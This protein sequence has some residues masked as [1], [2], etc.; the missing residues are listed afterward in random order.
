MQLIVKKIEKKEVEKMEKSFSKEF[1][2][3]INQPYYS[4]KVFKFYTYK[5][6]F[7]IEDEN[8][9]LKIDAEHYYDWQYVSTSYTWDYIFLAIADKKIGID[10]ETIKE[11][12]PEMIDF[13]SKEEYDFLWEKTR[14]N[15]FF[16][17]TAEECIIKTS[18]ACFFEDGKNVKIKSLE[19]KEQEIWGLSFSYE[20]IMTL[21]E[22]DYKV[23]TWKIDNLIY[24]ISMLVKN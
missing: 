8:L 18:N 12:S 5:R 22:K 20:S 9:L 14:E 11:R 23:Y 10:I 3:S 4:Q 16:L 7:N 15:F 19:K 21:N 24:S 6:F 2:Q 1:L 17:R 13:F